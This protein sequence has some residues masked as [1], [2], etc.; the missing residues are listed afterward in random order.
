MN[1]IPTPLPVPRGQR[2]SGPGCLLVV[3]GLVV[4]CILPFAGNLR[5]GL[6]EDTAP[7]AVVGE[8]EAT[9]VLSKS[10]AEATWHL[11]EV[12][13]VGGR[14]AVTSLRLDV[15]G[16]GTTG[17]TTDDVAVAVYD[18]ATGAALALDTSGNPGSTGVVGGG[19][20][21][22]CRSLVICE[23][24]TGSHCASC[25]AHAFVRG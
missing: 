6:G 3:V 24:R 17:I 11:T 25:G 14:S 15:I 19:L 5:N 7:R 12:V 21:V 16:L 22:P 20:V 23:G 1:L 8:S 13:H 4:L 18:E 9:V 10:E 2:G